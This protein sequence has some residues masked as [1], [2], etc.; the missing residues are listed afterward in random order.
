MGDNISEMLDSVSLICG[1][2]LRNNLKLGRCQE[3]FPPPGVAGIGPSS[4]ILD[5]VGVGFDSNIFC[6]GHGDRPFI[7]RISCFSL[8]AGDLV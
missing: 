4:R 7:V 3:P 8:G 2:E 6:D 1:A 5:I